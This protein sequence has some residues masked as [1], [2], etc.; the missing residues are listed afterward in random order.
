MARGGGAGGRGGGFSGGGFSGGGFRGGSSFRPTPRPV[1]HHHPRPMHR[2]HGPGMGGYPGGNGCGCG[3]I[4]MLPILFFLL[5]AMLFGKTGTQVSPEPDVQ[6][7]QGSYDER[8]IEDY[9]AQQY[10]AAFGTASAYEDNLLLTFLISE[11]RSDFSYIAWV[12]DHINDAT[13]GLLGG[14]DTLLG[15]TLE[16]YVQYGYENT[17]SD[18]L[19][20]ALGS[21]AGE[22]TAASPQGSY[23]CTETHS[24]PADQLVNDSSLSLDE[25]MLRTALREF[26]DETG[27]PIVLVIEDEADIFG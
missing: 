26:T 4:L 19:S 23:L 2:H 6:I 1:H 10:E 13:F 12:G 22:I 8:S 24:A 5:L 9:A 20:R 27:I 15:R 11:N 17:L 18:D 3:G 21:L 14:N 7:G 25:Q 16:R